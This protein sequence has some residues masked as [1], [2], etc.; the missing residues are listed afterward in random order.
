MTPNLPRR[1]VLYVNPQEQ[2]YSLFPALLSAGWQ[3][4]P[5][6]SLDHAHSLPHAL[7]CAVGVLRLQDA[8]DVSQLPAMERLIGDGQRE[9]IALLPGDLADDPGV[10]R[11]IA[12]CCFDYLTLPVDAGRITATLGHAYGMAALK[13][14]NC[15]GPIASSGWA[16][17]HLIGDSEAMA[18][19]RRSVGKLAQSRDPAL[20]TGERGSGKA[21]AARAIHA[22]SIRAD[23]PFVTLSCAAISP[24]NYGADLL[25]QDQSLF[26]G[27]ARR[28]VGRVEAAAGGTLYLEEVAELSADLQ[29]ELVDFLLQQRLRRADGMQPRLLDVRVVAA[30]AEPL[31]SAVAAGRFRADLLDLLQVLHLHVPALREHR[32]DIE[33]LSRHFLLEFRPPGRRTPR[34]FAPEAMHALHR[35]AWTGNVGELSNRIQRAVVLGEG[36]L[37]SSADLGLDEAPAAARSLTLDDARD[38]AER[39]ILL[40]A[41]DRHRGNVTRASRELGVSRVTLY[42]LL[43]KHHI[44]GERSTADSPA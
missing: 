8:A 29:A 16:N 35:H 12:D 10:R 33:A 4:Q 3:P 44:R 28:H 14:W 24:Q 37:I 15:D 23:G 42:R 25:G 39:R 22:E 31:E 21:L 43:D 13:R 6:G 11:L 2:C 34:A 40:E 17:A 9:W 7:D 26:A 1:S 19:L 30:T 38:E 20:I 5:V 36:R 18:A 27:M 32:S 41:L